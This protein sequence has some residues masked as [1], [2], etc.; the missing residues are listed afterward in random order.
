[1]ATVLRTGRVATVCLSSL[2]PGAGKRGERSLASALALLEQALVAWE[3]C[4]P[5]PPAVPR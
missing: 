4:P 3:R 2:N 1:M 5:P